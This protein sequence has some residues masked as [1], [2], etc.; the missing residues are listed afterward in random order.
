MKEEKFSI[1]YIDKDGVFHSI[2]REETREELKERIQSYLSKGFEIVAIDKVIVQL[3][4][5]PIN[6]KEMVK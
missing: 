4:F 1:T 3:A 5:E 6:W 2:E